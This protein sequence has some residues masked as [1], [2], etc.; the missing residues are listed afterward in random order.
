LAGITALL[1]RKRFSEANI[2]GL[3]ELPG[4][5]GPKKKLHLISKIANSVRLNSF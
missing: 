2:A 3:L 4:G 5:I 1:I